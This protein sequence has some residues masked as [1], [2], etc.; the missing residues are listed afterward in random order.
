V[1]H[2]VPVRRWMLF[3]AIGSL[4]I[5]LLVSCWPV[6]TYAGSGRSTLSTIPS[7]RGSKSPSTRGS[8]SPSTRRSKS[9]DSDLDDADFSGRAAPGSS[10]GRSVGT[11]RAG[12]SGYGTYNSKGIERFW[13]HYHGAQREQKSKPL[14]REK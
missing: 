12:Q 4:A 9:L 1:P 13:S 3:P 10:G 6:G 7:A 5:V 2:A 8:K 14:D 11:G